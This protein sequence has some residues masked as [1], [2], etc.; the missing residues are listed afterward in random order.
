[1]IS[2]LLI[3]SQNEFAVFSFPTVSSLTK[4]LGQRIG[5]SRLSGAI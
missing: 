4:R 2:V 5:A 3:F 1:M